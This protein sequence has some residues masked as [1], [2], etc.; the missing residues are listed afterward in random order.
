MNTCLLYSELVVTLETAFDHVCELV[1]SNLLKMAGSTK[2]LVAQQS[3]TTVT[4]I[5]NHTSA[6][7]RTIPHM[8]WG[9]LQDRTP[10]TRA[11]ASAHIKTYIEVH[12]SKAK[13]AIETSGGLDTL[14]NSVKKGLGDPNPG[15]RENAR[16][17]YWLLNAVWKDK[18]TAIMAGLD[19]AARKQLEKACPDPSLL[20]GSTDTAQTTKKNSVA[21]VIAASRAK[22][23]AIAIDPPTLRHQATSTAR[24]TTSPKR[25]LSPSLSNGSVGSPPRSRPVVVTSHTRTATHSRSPRR[26]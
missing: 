4:I 7:P 6:Q 24:T 1:L 23:K 25:P 15:V 9:V 26:A 21:A 3:Q 5:L 10:Q 8:L 12:S 20:P 22:A 14:V 17:A 13:H 2:K 16:S 19:S 18:G 11:Y